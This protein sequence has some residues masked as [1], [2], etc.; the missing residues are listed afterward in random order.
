MVKEDV[1]RG[2]GWVVVVGRKEDGGYG[3]KAGCKSW[4]V[5]WWATRGKEGGGSR[6]KNN[7]RKN[8]K[9]RN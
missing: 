9:C 5:S 3:G 7:A 6:R 1:A 2:V 4:E 8:N